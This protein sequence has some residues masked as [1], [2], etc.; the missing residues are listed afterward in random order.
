LELFWQVTA[1]SEFG[2]PG[3]SD[4][5][6]KTTFDQIISERGF[7]VKNPVPFTFYDICKRLKISPSGTNKRHIKEAIVRIIATTVN[8]KGIFY[9]KEEQKYVD[10]YFHLYDRV[11]FAG[12]KLEDGTVADKNF[13]FLGDWYIKSLNA[14]FVKPIDF[15]YILSLNSSVASRLY[16]YLGV[17]FFGMFR[18]RQDCYSEDYQEICQILPL[19]TK[20]HLSAAKQV[21]EPIHQ[22]LIDKSF[23][24]KVEWNG[25]QINYYPGGKARRDYRENLTKI[26]KQIE[27]PLSEDEE[28]FQLSEKQIVMGKLI[29]R[30]ITK[31]TARRLVKNYDLKLIE[32]KIELVDYLKETDSPLVEKKPAGYLRKAIEEDYQPTEGFTTKAQREEKNKVERFG[33]FGNIPLIGHEAKGMA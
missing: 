21:L 6:V 20:E 27:L 23:L 11:V 22:K 5:K 12:E 8:S 14:F 30:R 3:P 29:E 17:K 13:L 10:D 24:S 28:Q 9:L 1:N 7:P 16:E 33:S 18:H 32:Q 2:Y 25:W 15:N 26:T 31:A 4:K 19:T